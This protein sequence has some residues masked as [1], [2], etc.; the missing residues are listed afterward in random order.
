MSLYRGNAKGTVHLDATGQA[1]AVTL[2]GAM[3]GVDIGALSRDAGGGASIAGSGSFTLSGTARGNSERDLVSTLAGKATFRVANGSLG[4]VDLGGM[5]KNSTS[6]FKGG[7]GTA[8]DHVSASYT[9]R[10]GI[11]HT[12]NLSVSTGSIDATGT[13]SVNLP[14]RTLDFRIEPKL[15]AGIVTVPVIVSGPWDHP[16]FQPDVAGIAKGIVTA[17]VNVIGGAAG[18]VGKAGQGVGGALKSLFGN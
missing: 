2:D 11:M 6:S 7:G 3:S 17:P 8:I 15:I 1:A 9:I 14:A 13:G 18:G 16:S 4:G 5:L 10:G 12:S